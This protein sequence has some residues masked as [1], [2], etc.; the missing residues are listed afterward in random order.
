M[1]RAVG[2]RWAVVA[3][4][5]VVTAAV[6]FAFLSSTAANQDRDAKASAAMKTLENQRGDVRSDI[7]RTAA[8]RV[9]L[10][11]RE[12]LKHARSLS[13]AFKSVA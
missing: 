13:E 2:T 1:K 6:A 9:A 10:D 5:L 7:M 4:F 12:D 3:G 8:N 11:A